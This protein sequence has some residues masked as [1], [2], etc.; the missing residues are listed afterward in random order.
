MFLGCF[1]DKSVVVTDET[2]L[3]RSDRPNPK[4]KYNYSKEN[5]DDISEPPRVTLEIKITSELQL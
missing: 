3:Q 4:I 1:S 2:S 5:E